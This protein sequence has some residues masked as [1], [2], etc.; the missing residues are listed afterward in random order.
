VL[1]GG[2]ALGLAHIGV[3]QW[4]EEHRI[5]INYVAG[6]SMGGLVGGMYATGNSPAEIRKLVDGIDWDIVLRGEVPY[7]DLSFRR[8]EDAEEFP[9]GLVFGIKDGV[10]FPEGFNSGH[11]VSLILDRVALPYS[12]IKSF[13]ELPSPF[14]CVGTDL[15]N[16]KAHTFREGD[17]SMALRSTVAS[18]GVH[19]GEIQQDGLCRR[20]V[21]GQPA[22]RCGAA[23]GGRSHH[24][25]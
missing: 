24:R 15:V 7:G 10:R 21:A 8:K 25:S 1:Q 9:N 16:N 6:T 11:Q 2:A 5:P 17:L 18:R 22:G 3:I 13:D 4:L 19:A 20:G 14:A 23:D 12:G